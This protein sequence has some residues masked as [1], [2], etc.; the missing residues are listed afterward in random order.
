SVSG[1]R[2][3]IRSC[4][5]KLRG[6]DG[7]R[8]GALVGKPLRFRPALEVLECR[9]APATAGV[10][11]S[12]VFGNLTITDNAATS[13]LTLSQ[14]AAGEITI[15]PDDGTPINGRAGPVTMEAETGNLNG[16][17]GAGMDTLTFDLSQH[18]IRD[19]NVAVTANTGA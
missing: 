8:E 11:A 2:R 17:L 9:L 7:G 16:P 3:S 6:G 10:T 1:F 18:D 12:V 19:D 4:V 13:Q 15:T 14:P 5:G